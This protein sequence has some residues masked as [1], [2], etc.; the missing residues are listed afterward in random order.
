M[1]ESKFSGFYAGRYRVHLSADCKAFGWNWLEEHTSAK[2]GTKAKYN[3]VDFAAQV[4]VDKYK[5]AAELVLAVQPI[6][7]EHKGIWKRLESFLVNLIKTNPQLFSQFIF[8]LAT[9]NAKNWLKAL[10]EPRQFEWLLRNM[11]TKDVANAIGQLVFADKPECRELGLFFF[12]KLGLTS[13]PPDAFKGVDETRVALAFYALQR[14][15]IHGGAVARFLIFLIPY[16]EKT[17]QALQ[18]E[19][20]NELVLQLKN[21]PGT[22]KKQF[23]AHADKYP[24]LKKALA[25][26]DAYFQALEITRQSAINHIQ[27]AG[28]DRSARLY[29]RRFANQ[30]SKGAEQLSIFTQLVKKVVLLYGKQWR[31]FHG[32]ILGKSSGLKE[33]STSMEFPR[34]ELIDPEGMEL[35]RLRAAI[36]IKEL[37][38]QNRNGG[39]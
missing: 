4:T 29:S 13:L 34:M 26:V 17:N 11:R 28:F 32:G 19:F 6:P 1:N 36:R 23:E 10:N 8:D 39:E 38:K 7:P 33:I 5:E 20:Y 35:R 24:V 14:S 3:V 21:Y 9:R 37:S 2:I 22:C 27:I 16:M 25:E 15:V 30:V 18:A 12:D 31:T